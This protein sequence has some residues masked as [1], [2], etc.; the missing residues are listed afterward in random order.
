MVLTTLFFVT[1]TCIVR[2]LGDNMPAAEGAFIRYA[3]GV[4]ILLPF[5]GPLLRNPP[6]PRAWKVYGIRTL[7]HGTAVLLWFYAMARVPIAEVTAIGYTAPIYVA[8]GAAVF[9]GES[10]KLR[11]IIAILVAFFGTLIIIRPGI[12]EISP[13]HLAQLAAAPCFACSF[14]M[15]KRMTDTVDATS[16]VLMLSIGCTVYLLPFAL[17]DWVHPTWEQVGWL[18]L[19]AIFATAGHWSMTRAFGCAP[20]TVTQ[21]IGFLQ[22]VWASF[23]GVLLFD[24]SIDPFVILGGAV[25]IGSATY[26]S[27][28]EAVAAR[29]ARTPPAAATK[30]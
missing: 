20:I 8:I 30:L 6:S 28:R 23:L 26:I 25:V 1:V 24:E 17:A 12:Q 22:L 7:F 2:H 29:Q 11:R 14:L 21:P 15:A 27:H 5:A 18:G 9:L 19:T 13:G 10:M 4:L 3:F 16:I